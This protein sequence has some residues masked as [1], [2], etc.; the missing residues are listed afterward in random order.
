MDNFNIRR[1]PKKPQKEELNMSVSPVCNRDGRKL[2]FVSFTDGK[3]TAEGEIPECR[4]TKNNGFD[5]GEV[6]QLEIYM[7]SE[8]PKL[9]KMASS[10]NV[11][12]AFMGKRE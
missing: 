6:A 7:K 10:V 3:R 12:D 1:Q 11:M 9:K 5:E 4:I 2:A 8:L